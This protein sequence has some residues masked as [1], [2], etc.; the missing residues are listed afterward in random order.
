V[1]RSTLRFSSFHGGL[2]SS[3]VDE[4][5]LLGFFLMLDWNDGQAQYPLDLYLGDM[6]FS[7]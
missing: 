2:P 1:T 5:E 4:S 3:G 7:P 6:K